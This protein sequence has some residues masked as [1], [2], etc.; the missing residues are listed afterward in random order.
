MKNIITLVLALFTLAY[1]PCYA[2]VQTPV[3]RFKMGMSDLLVNAGELLQNEPLGAMM[4]LQ[5][6]LLWDVTS[7]NSRIGF[8]FLAD[9]SS[10]YGMTPVTG[11]GVSGYYYLRGL[12][13]AYEIIDKD[14]LTQKS[15]P[16]LFTFASLTPVNFNINRTDPEDSSKEFAPSAVVYELMLGVGYE[17]PLKPNMLVS[18]EIARRDGTLSSL[19]KDLS[20]SGMMFSFSFITSYY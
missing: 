17:Y 1:S 12:T 16:G 14:I 10:N 9:I 3:V 5:P 4:T 20:Y 2:E 15:K 7:L 6:T 19:S 11:I 18:F 8:H 13:S